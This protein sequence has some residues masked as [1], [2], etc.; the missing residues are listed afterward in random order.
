[1]VKFHDSFSIFSQSDLTFDQTGLTSQVL[2]RAHS[3]SLRSEVALDR[4]DSLRGLYLVDPARS[5][6]ETE[7][8]VL[9]QTQ[10]DLNSPTSSLEFTTLCETTT[11]L[12]P[13]DSTRDRTDASRA[14]LRLGTMT[15]LSRFARFQLSISVLCWMRCDFTTSACLS[16]LFAG[17]QVQVATLQASATSERTRCRWRLAL[18]DNGDRGGSCCSL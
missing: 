1:M 7:N 11:Q 16:V 10:R 8:F 4:R 5:S 9:L 18:A 14:Y 17:V 12:L 3:S 2:A 15:T 13:K 6:I